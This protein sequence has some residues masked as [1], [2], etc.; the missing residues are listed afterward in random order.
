[1]EKG[2]G[3]G[4]P[5]NPTGRFERLSIEAGPDVPAGPDEIA[6]EVYRDTSRSVINRNDSPDIPFDA[7]LN[8]YRGCEH[9]CAYC[10]ARPYHEYLGLSAGLDFETKIFAKPDAAALLR[11]ELSRRTWR[12]QV[13][14]LSGVT[15]PYQ[16]V[17]RRLEITRGCLEALAECRNPVAIITKGALVV[18]DIDVLGELARDG[19]VSV[20]I[21]VTTLDERLRGAL[22]PRTPTVDARL[23]AM[24]RLNDR[25][26]PAGI[27][28][29]PVIPG[30]NDHEIPRILARAAD[31]GARF[32]GYTLLRLPH[33]VG[34]LF[35]AWL[36]RHCPD[37]RHKVLASIRGTR[38]GRLSDARFGSRMRGT[39]HRAA[40]IADVF[41]VARTRAGIAGGYPDL[42]CQS[43]RR[44][45]AR[46]S[47]VT[48]FD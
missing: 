11:F 7:S 30:L 22:E 44:P 29:A 27:A 38:E 2:R 47:Q 26:I 42:S 23:D 8:P 28:V 16:P 18:R 4:T 9:G 14:A 21:S 37:R 48:L 5:D 19:A 32:A 36:E 43:F 39:G 6:T 1:M 41:R 46:P 24:A 17:E 40:L 35:A 15:D 13:L 45:A 20:S 33:G 12:P 10:Y 31:A 34:D 3:R 25:G